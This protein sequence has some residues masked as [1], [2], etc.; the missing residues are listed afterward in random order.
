MDFRAGRTDVMMIQRLLSGFIVGRHTDARI[1]FGPK[2]YTAHKTNI[3]GGLKILT[4]T[5]GAKE[6]EVDEMN[7]KYHFEIS[8]LLE[9][10]NVSRSFVEGRDYWLYTNRRFIH[11]N[12]KGISG[13][14]VRYTSI[15]YRSMQGFIFETAGNMNRDAEIRMYTNIAD[16][17]MFDMPRIINLYHPKQKVLVKHTDIYEIGKLILNHTVFDK[18]LLKAN[19]DDL[20]PEIDTTY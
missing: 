9:E 1:I 12:A 4:L 6:V 18:T 16:V 5:G 11:I 15:P 19:E 3:F 7:A 17:V 8:M 2:N 13:K 14:K 20:V 10:E